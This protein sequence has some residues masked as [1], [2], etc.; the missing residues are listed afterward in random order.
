MRAVLP[1]QQSAVRK[2]HFILERGHGTDTWLPKTESLMN[3]GL[4]E[5]AYLSVCSKSDLKIKCKPKTG[6]NFVL[7][8]RVDAFHR[9]LLC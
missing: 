1:W 2:E 5:L 7:L 4:M 3:S 8:A 9:R 6:A